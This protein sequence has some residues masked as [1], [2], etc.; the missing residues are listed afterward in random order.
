MNKLRVCVCVCIYTHI[1]VKCQNRCK[2]FTKCV[3]S[4]SNRKKSRCNTNSIPSFIQVYYFDIRD[5]HPH[6]CGYIASQYF[7]HKKS[8][9]NEFEESCFQGEV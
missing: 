8:K 7:V 5:R 4:A 6:E 1:Y 3:Y 2:L 9:E